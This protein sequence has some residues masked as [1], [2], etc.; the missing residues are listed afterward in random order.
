M[1]LIQSLFY[2]VRVAAQWQQRSR[3]QPAAGV[4]LLFNSSLSFP[5]L[6]WEV[7]V[8]WTPLKLTFRATHYLCGLPMPLLSAVKPH[9]H[10]NNANRYFF[11]QTFEF[12]PK[13]RL[14]VAP[15][16]CKD[17]FKFIKFKLGV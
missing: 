11:L 3:A 1:E 4:C 7:C 2:Y 17:L 13:I 14:K 6:L 5:Y 12:R 16:V 9:S 10:R 8:H 15:V